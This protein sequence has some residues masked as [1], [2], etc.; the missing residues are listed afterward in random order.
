MYLW[1]KYFIVVF[2]LLFFNIALSESVITETAIK[3]QAILK[4]AFKTT[5]SKDFIATIDMPLKFKELPQLTSL[6]FF[7]KHYA[8]GHVDMRLDMF[9]KKQCVASFWKNNQGQYATV[10]EKH[11]KGGDFNILFW[12]ENLWLPIYK[13]E[14]L[15]NQYTISSEKFNDRLCN[16]ITLIM[17]ASKE[18]HSKLGGITGL[19]ITNSN[20]AN[21]AFES[22]AVYR[23]FLI[24]QED[25]IIYSRKH[26]NGNHQ[27]L[28]D[29]KLKKV[30]FSPNWD[31]YPDIFTTPCVPTIYA[32]S[33]DEV[34]LELQIQQS[35]FLSNFIK[36]QKIEFP[37]AYSPKTPEV[38]LFIRKPSFHHDSAEYSIISSS[39]A[40]PFSK[41]PFV[42]NVRNTRGMKILDV[43]L[44]KKDMLNDG[45]IL[46]SWRIRA[47][48]NTYEI[49]NVLFDG[50]HDVTVMHGPD[51]SVRIIIPHHNENQ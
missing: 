50:K 28:M 39:L 21:E 41:L 33:D 17:T 42:P 24:G 32:L 10:G 8:D 12:L 47:N 36:K 1:Y 37:K 16:K 5:A 49:N 31:E 51:W 15:F 18:K 11:F 3:G 30:N 34:L 2:V 45:T 4:E 29:F 22:H 38:A 35:H 14:W 48:Q 40:F 13:N 6:R 7:H 44:S 19:Y 27:C 26:L 20:D 25:Y 46:S 9:V 43:S 23:E